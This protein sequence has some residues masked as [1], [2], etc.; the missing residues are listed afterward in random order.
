MQNLPKIIFTRV[1][2]VC[3]FINVGH[4]IPLHTLVDDNDI[5]PVINNRLNTKSQ[6][7]HTI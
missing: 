6:I 7:T 1:L 2:I 4:D 3:I 5:S